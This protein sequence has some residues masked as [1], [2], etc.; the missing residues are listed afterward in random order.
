MPPGTGDRWPELVAAHFAALREA[1]QG[2]ESAEE[3]LRGTHARLLPADALT[4]ELADAMRYA[5]VVADGL[6]LIHALDGPTSVRVLT[7]RDVERAGLGELDEA[8]FANLLRVPVEHR[9]V[10]VERGV[11]LHS[12]GRLGSSWTGS[13]TSRPRSSAG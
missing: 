8:G 13:T 3:L 12:L 5:R 7:D 11:P 1:G 9:E 4:P 6:V 2:G 10:T